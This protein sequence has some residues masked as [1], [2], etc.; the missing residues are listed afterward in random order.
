MRFE[1]IVHGQQ[2]FFG[3]SRMAVR[4]RRVVTAQALVFALPSVTETC[5]PAEMAA[6]LGHGG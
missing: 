1:I 5:D 3:G 2:W 6:S 4:S